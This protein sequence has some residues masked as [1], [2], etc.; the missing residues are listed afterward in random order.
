MSSSTKIKILSN[1]FVNVCYHCDVVHNQD[2]CLAND[3]LL[4]CNESQEYHPH[5]QEIKRN[6]SYPVLTTHWPQLA[7]AE[8]LPSQSEMHLWKEEME[9]A[10]GVDLLQDSFCIHHL[11]LCQ[12][13][14][15]EG[16]AYWLCDHARPVG[17][18]YYWSEWIL[19]LLCWINCSREA[20]KFLPQPC[21]QLVERKEHNS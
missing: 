17:F 19:S 14:S 21:W 10:T 18:T 9:G 7:P 13:S 3:P 4:E 16:Q 8:V 15:L 5:L 20:Q 2:E 6:V 12:Q 1:P 11:M